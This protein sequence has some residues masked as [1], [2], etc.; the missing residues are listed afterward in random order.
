MRFII[1][2]FSFVVANISICFAISD[3][4]IDV[5]APSSK[6]SEL[7]LQ[8]IE[9]YLESIGVKANV[10][11]NI[12]SDNEPLYSNTD[13][14]RAESLVKALTNPKSIAIW[15]IRGGRG[16]N[17]L[18]PYLEKLPDDVKKKIAQN[19]NRKILMGFSDVSVLHIYLQN[20]YDW[21]TLHS[22]MLEQIVDNKISQDSIDKL[23]LLISGYRN[24]I[25]F[26]LKM[27]DNGIELND[28]ILE[29][30]VVGGS[31]SLVRASIGTCW[32]IDTKDKILFLEEVE[33]DPALLELR[34]EH[35][36]QAHILD[37]VQAVIFG[38]IL[39][40]N[41]EQL[42]ELVKH[43]FAQSVNFPVF[44]LN[45]IGHARTNYPLPL[46]TRAVINHIKGN[47]FSMTVE[48][49]AE[50]RRR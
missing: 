14:F 36:K 32:Q 30:K 21:S 50:W 2:L 20:K 29:S 4:I 1:L 23:E 46:N 38:D 39:C 40:T 33:P 48:M 49:P 11:E 13:E 9:D 27:I 44:T 15:C 28:G 8:L 34:L 47:R 31:I 35:L 10:P 25:K 43:R 3:T 37:E 17:R 45:G 24:N 12:Y 18:I 41:D 26:N 5:I 19:K 16:A 22:P 7:N 6:G 42:L